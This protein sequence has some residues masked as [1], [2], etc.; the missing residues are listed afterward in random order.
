MCTNQV[1]FD[2]FANKNEFFISFFLRRNKKSLSDLVDQTIYCKTLK[3]RE[4]LIFVQIR[5][6]VVKGGQGLYENL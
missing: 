4:H 5:Y 3:F 6:G 1:E 2:H